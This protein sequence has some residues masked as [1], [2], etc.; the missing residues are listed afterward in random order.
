M[1]N[2]LTKALLPLAVFLAFNTVS[3]AQTTTKEEAAKAKV[4]AQA[5]KKA[6]EEVKREVKTALDAKA[7]AEA[8]LKE[9]PADS[10]HQ[11]RNAD[12]E[13]A[14]FKAYQKSSERLLQITAQAT[15]D[16][17]Y[18]VDSYKQSLED[19]KVAQREKR[20]IKKT[21]PELK[22]DHALK[23][24]KIENERDLAL[25]EEIKV[26]LP[27]ALEKVETKYESR[28]VRAQEREANAAER[29][30]ERDAAKAAGE[31]PGLLH[32][33]KIKNPF[34]KAP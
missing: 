32:G 26:Y 18:A 6:K 7:Q 4:E 28:L 27:E 14:I 12:Y 33:I 34:K 17:V 23:I 24:K 31:T 1:V 15:R 8:Y 21:A 19:L 30:A 11:Y 29:Q 5:E 9:H 22:S 13:V 20:T 25:M 2:V 10:A 3:S 16:S